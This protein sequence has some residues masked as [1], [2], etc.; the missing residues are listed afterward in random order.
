MG[1]IICDLHEESAV[2]DDFVLV[3]GALLGLLQEVVEEVFVF[4][5]GLSHAPVRRKQ[6]SISRWMGRPSDWVV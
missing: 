2:D 4:R 6:G 3:D 1:L 5:I